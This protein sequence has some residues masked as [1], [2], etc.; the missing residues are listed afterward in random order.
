MLFWGVHQ[1]MVSMETLGWW[2][3]AGDNSCSGGLHLE[4]NTHSLTVL[5]QYESY[6]TDYVY[7]QYLKTWMDTHTHTHFQSLFK[8]IRVKQA[9][10][11]SRSHKKIVVHTIQL[12]LIKL[13]LVGGTQVKAI[14]LTKSRF[15]V[16]T[17][18]MSLID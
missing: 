7:A 12:R 3:M 4:E 8:M 13:V 1:L 9:P 16:V 11:L 15:F 18:F 14:N 10:H 5:L 17:M 6:I 2:D